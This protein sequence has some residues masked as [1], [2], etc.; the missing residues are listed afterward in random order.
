MANAYNTLVP[1]HTA[2]F[3]RPGRA[4]GQ[5]EHDGAG[6]VFAVDTDLNHSSAFSCCICCVAWASYLSSLR[7]C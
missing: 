3:T 4:R 5:A 6:N 7:Q 1:R 2:A